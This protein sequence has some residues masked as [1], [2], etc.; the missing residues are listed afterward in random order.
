[1]MLH[2]L[3]SMTLSMREV[4]LR[5]TGWRLLKMENIGTS[6]SSSQA[7]SKSPSFINSVFY[8]RSDELKEILNDLQRNDLKEEINDF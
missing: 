6:S 2:L 1:M 7:S 4:E 3:R 8:N 5:E